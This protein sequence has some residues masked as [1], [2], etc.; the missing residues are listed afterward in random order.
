[1]STLKL[2]LEIYVLLECNGEEATDLVKKDITKLLSEYV[3]STRGNVVKVEFV[4]P[5]NVRSKNLV[6]STI[7][8]PTKAILLKYAN[9]RKVIA[10]EELYDVRNGEVV[11]FRGEQILTDAIKDLVAEERKVIYFLAGHGECDVTDVSLTRGL[12]S[13]ANVLRSKNYDVKVLDFDPKSDIPN[14]AALVVLW[15]PK[16]A[17]LPIEVSIFKKFLDEQGGKIMI[18]LGDADDVALTEFFADH[19]IR[20]DNHSKILSSADH[21]KFYHDLVI[22]RYMPH[23]ITCE[24]INFKIPVVCGEA[25]EVR[26][27]DWSTEDDQFVVTDLLQAEGILEPSE[28]CD[29]FIVAALSEK[30]TSISIDILNGKL[31]VF[32]CPDF[33]INSRI[34]ILGN[35]MLF[36]SAVDYMCNAGS[37]SDITSNPVAKYRLTLTEKQYDSIVTFSYTLCCAFIAIGIIVYF[38]RRK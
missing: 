18:G 21:A 24:L 38:F 7:F 20:A 27:A 4:D 17:L 26:E 3:D 30:Q 35:R 6:E 23:K 16:A 33:A 13:L 8:L 29:K 25:H 9:K 12:S 1:M 5:G 11:G 14:D 37:E 19:G 31:L 36:C 34:N 2:P 32:G 22:N 10:I 15:D 28:H